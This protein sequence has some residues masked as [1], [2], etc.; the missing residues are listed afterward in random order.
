MRHGF[1]SVAQEVRDACILEAVYVQIIQSGRIHTIH[2]KQRLDVPYYILTLEY[3]S[4][5][6]IP[7]N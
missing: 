6:G 3:E 5:V 4:G 7:L 1:A 2:S